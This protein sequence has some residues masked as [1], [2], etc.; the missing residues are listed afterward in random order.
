[1]K[2]YTYLLNSDHLG[3]LMSHRPSATNFVKFLVVSASRMYTLA[4]FSW[5]SFLHFIQNPTECD[6]ATHVPGLTDS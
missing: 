4:L 2:L 1:M 3:F 5:E 6:I